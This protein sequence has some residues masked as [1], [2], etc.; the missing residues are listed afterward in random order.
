MIPTSTGAAKAVGLVLPELAGK[1]DGVA[2]HVPTPNVSAVDLKFVA[3]RA[4]SKEEING[5]VKRAA[6]QQ[7]SGILGYTD[8][9]NV[10]M[11]FNHD[12]RSKPDDRYRHGEG[13]ADLV[14]RLRRLI[15][16]PGTRAGLILCGARG[17]MP[18]CVLNSH[19][20]R[21]RTKVAHAISTA[22]SWAARSLKRAR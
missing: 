19:R 12:P 2:I 18:S 5:A 10:S 4:T 17:C 1:R 8:R 11:D 16:R 21:S 9:P 6:E 3:K 15:R 7:L 20:L 22:T 13:E 14:L